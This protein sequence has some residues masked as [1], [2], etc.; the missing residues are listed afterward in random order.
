M[1]VNYSGDEL[2]TATP[3]DLDASLSRQCAY[4]VGTVSCQV[5]VWKTVAESYSCYRVAGDTLLAWGF[6]N[7]YPAGYFISHMTSPRDTFAMLYSPSPDTFG[8]IPYS[9]TPATAKARSSMQ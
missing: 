3:M 9:A 5:K 1:K 2:R 8:G 7:Y 4:R 6:N